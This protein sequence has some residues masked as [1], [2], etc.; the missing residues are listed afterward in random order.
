MNVHGTETKTIATV[1]FRGLKC[2][3]KENTYFWN[4][5]VEVPLKNI[6]KKLLD[7]KII[8]LDQNNFNGIAFCLIKSC[9][10]RRY[11]E[12]KKCFSFTT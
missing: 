6:T 7:I 2:F 3:V 11:I 8:H 9:V 10:F 4:L 1:K 5:L 12:A